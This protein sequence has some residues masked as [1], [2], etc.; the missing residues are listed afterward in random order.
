MKTLVL[1][2]SGATGRQVVEQLLLKGQPVKL[3]ARSLASLPESWNT[4]HQ[5]TIIRVGIS[6]VSVDEM[7]ELLSDCQSVVSCLGHNLSLK[8]LFGKPRNLVAGAVELVCKAIEKNA[9]QQ[10]VKI[11]W[12]NTAGSRNNDLNEKQ[13]VAEKLVMALIRVLV[14]P[15]SDNEKAAGFLRHGV[16]KNHAGIQWVAVRPDTLIDEEKV[17]EYE[18]YPSPVRSALFRPGKTSRINTAHFMARLAT[19]ND[20]WNKWQGQMPVIYN[21]TH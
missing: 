13:S 14:P 12:M 4:N 20:L 10:A 21:K 18:L 2:A 7:A 11:V 15:H 19:D 1:G 8:G 6:E 5:V 3:V 9:R 16:G 17:S